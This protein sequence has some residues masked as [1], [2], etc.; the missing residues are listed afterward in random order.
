MLLKPGKPVTIYSGAGIIGISVSKTLTKQNVGKRDT[1][2]D[3][4]LA[5]K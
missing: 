3:R 5:P 2:C 4:N 1:S